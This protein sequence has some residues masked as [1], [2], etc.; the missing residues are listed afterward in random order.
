MTFT[1]AAPVEGTAAATASAAAVG[2]G[3]AIGDCLT[4]TFS[5]SSQGA[6]GSPVICGANAG[7]HMILDV[8][9]RKGCQTA[10]FTIGGATGGNN[11]MR[12]WDI[13]VT[14]YG[15]GNQDVSGPPG[16]LQYFTGE[17]GDIMSFNFPTGNAV[18]ATATH[19]SNQKY[20]VCVRREA[21]MGCICY[22]AAEP[23]GAGLTVATQG[24]FGVSASTV[25]AAAKSGTDA[26]CTADWIEIPDAFG[27]AQLPTIPRG[28]VTNQGATTA[29]L[30]QKFCGRK[31]NNQRKQAA[32]ITVCSG[33]LPFRLGVN[34][35]ADEVIGATDAT[36]DERA[37]A[38]GG[39]VGFKLQYKQV[40]CT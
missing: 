6:A 27:N 32:T 29:Q 26:D 5:I 40:A 8:D 37:I 33:V 28:A 25:A 18:T 9:T 38:T 12:S 19:L 34:F 30:A 3:N 7:Q 23:A 21:S 20:S 13:K 22:S 31:L 4:D 15:C 17:T 11:F 39:I 2:E 24:S 14:Q 36:D 16:C 35:D 1:L 10:A